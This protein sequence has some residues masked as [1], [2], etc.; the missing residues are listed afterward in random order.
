VEGGGHPPPNAATA[1]DYITPAQLK[2]SLEMTGQTYADADI[3][4]AITAASGLVDDITGQ[5]F[6]PGTAGETRWPASYGDYVL[7]N[8]PVVIDT[9]TVWGTVWE[10]DVDYGR[11]GDRVLR[12]LLRAFPRSRRAVAVTGTWGYASVPAEVK[13]ATSILATQILRR[14]REAPF[15]IVES[16]D[17]G[18]ATQIRRYDP[19]VTAL[20]QRYRPLTIR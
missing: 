19:H 20:L 5:K 11:E 14:V 12:P 13:T 8:A 4:A 10:P 15:G 1:M 9:V 7:L 16:L 3:Q 2:A 6:T 17:G 18:V